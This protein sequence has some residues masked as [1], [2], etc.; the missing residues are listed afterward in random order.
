MSTPLPIMYHVIYKQFAADQGLTRIFPERQ[1][2]LSVV[3]VVQSVVLICSDG[4]RL[5]LSPNGVLY[6]M[7]QPCTMEVSEGSEDVQEASS[8]QKAYLLLRFAAHVRDNQGK[9]WSRSPR[10]R[11]SWPLICDTIFFF[12]TLGVRI[13]MH[14]CF[15][16][17]EKRR[18]C[19]GV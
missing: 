13:R 10:D 5:C 16:Q 1:A 7:G 18:E 15:S 11:V 8:S 4:S 14:S 17:T 19:D 9:G 2:Y 12:S 6:H 3:A